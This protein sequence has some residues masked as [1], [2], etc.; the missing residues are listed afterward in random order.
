MRYRRGCENYSDCSG[1][2]MHVITWF[3]LFCSDQLPRWSPDI[4]KDPRFAVLMRRAR[5]RSQSLLAVR[6]SALRWASPVLLVAMSANSVKLIKRDG[7]FVTQ[8]N[9]CKERAGGK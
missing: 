9:D 3:G 7:Q 8:G 6:P 1:L 2:R 5:T 4:S